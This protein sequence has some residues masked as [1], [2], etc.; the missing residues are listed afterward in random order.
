[1]TR[2]INTEVSTPS[3]SVARK[4]PDAIIP[5]FG[6][7]GRLKAGASGYFQPTRNMMITGGSIS[8]NGDGELPCLFSILKKEPFIEQPVLI[9]GETLNELDKKVLFS[10]EALVTP[11]DNIFVVAWAN[12]YHSGVTIQLVGV[13]I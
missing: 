10:M 9:G 5:P 13:Q 6:F 12:S 3:N 4:R 11:Y 7:V 1:M 8:S 2:Y